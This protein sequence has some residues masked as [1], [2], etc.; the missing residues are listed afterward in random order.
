MSVVLNHA[1]NGHSATSVDPDYVVFPSA[2]S[3]DIN[4]VDD[5]ISIG[6]PNGDIADV[7]AANALKVDGSAVIQPISA[8]S[9]PLPSGAATA[10]RQDTSNTSLAS[11]D[12]HIDVALSSRLKPADTLTAVTT[13][14]TITNVVHVDDNS[15]SLTVDGAI[16]ANAGTNLNTSLL[17]LDSTVAKDTSLSTI[18]TSVNTLLKPAN[19]L[20]AV[21]TLG[22][23]T[24]VVHVDDNSG[25]LTIDGTV[26][27]SQSGTWNINNVSG[28]VSLPTGASTETT[29]SARLA[30]AT[31]TTRINTLGQKAMASSTPVV[32]ASDQSVLSI[33]GVGFSTMTQTAVNATNVNAT[34]LAANASRRYVL[35]YNQSGSTVFVSFGATAAVANTGLRL[36]N[37]SSYEITAD[38]LFLGALNVIKVGAAAASIDVMEGA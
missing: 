27:A 31:F 14:G 28:T 36:A 7:T 2:Q 23:I 18:N 10:A 1:I 3:I 4:S 32:I 15:G 8:A 26:A 38:N 5:S 37:N 16:T 6:D 35:V 11:I 29:L 20:A 33:K 13:V 22:T 30:E 25:S 17:A 34:L 24:N 12:G 19:T 21:T 9:L